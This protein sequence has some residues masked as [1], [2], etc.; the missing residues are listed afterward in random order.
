MSKFLKVAVVAGGG[1]FGS[2]SMAY[3]E[4][5][6][7]VP[8]AFIDV[9]PSRA[10]ESHE[11]ML[12]MHLKPALEYYIEDEPEEK[13]E[14]ERLQFVVEALEERGVVDSIWDVMDEVD[15]F[16]VCTPNK[17]HVPYAIIALQHGKSVMTEKPPARNWWETRLL[18]EVARESKARYQINENEFFRPLWHAI[19]DAV[20][21]GKVGQ[22]KKVSAQLGHN[23]PSWGY[24]GHFFNPIYNGGG[25]TQDLGVHALGLM[26]TSLGWLNGR[27]L[28][29]LKLASLQVKKMEKRREKREMKTVRG[30]MEFTKL[31]FEDYAKFNMKFAHPDGYEFRGTLETAWSQPIQGYCKIEGRDGVLSPNVVKGQQVV[32]HYDNAG[33]LVETIKP[34]I[35]KYGNRDSHEREVL[36]FTDIVNNGLGPSIAN[37]DVACNLQQMITL[38][39]YGNAFAGKGEVTPA[40]LEAWVDSMEKKIGKAAEVLVDELVLRLM[41][42]FRADI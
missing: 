36:Y 18:A 42:P 29:D 27:P 31:D 8:V 9:I 12:E 3:P 14:I 23:G 39:Y 34:K 13:E 33:Q 37:E 10:K 25:C 11:N 6:N 5:P 28:Q 16:D 20:A 26:M 2:H 21:D 40:D 4:N 1:I 38:A 41:K 17:Y 22:I 19:A 35:D 24:H 32:E 30:A 15:M 7:A